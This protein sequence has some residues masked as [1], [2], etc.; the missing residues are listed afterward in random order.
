MVLSGGMLGKGN[1]RIAVEAPATPDFRT[2][3]IVIDDARLRASWGNRLYR[4]VIGWPSL[5]STGEL[6]FEITAT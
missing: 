5:P 1:V 3:E 6:K 4:T 2:E